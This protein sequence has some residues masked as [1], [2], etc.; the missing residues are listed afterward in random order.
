MTARDEHDDDLEP[1]VVEGAE[2]ETE[3]Y[4]EAEDDEDVAAEA[5]SPSRTDGGK[6]LP[7]ADAE[8]HGRSTERSQAAGTVAGTAPSTRSGSTRAATD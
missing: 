5:S 1:E 3:R 6:I 4:E 2:I 8:D 7:D